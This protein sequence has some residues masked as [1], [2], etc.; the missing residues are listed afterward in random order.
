MVANAMN[1]PSPEN[2]LR[3]KRI[4]DRLK[5]IKGEASGFSAFLKSE[6]GEPTK[7]AIAL[8]EELNQIGGHEAMRYASKQ[9]SILDQRELDFA[10][11]A[12]TEGKFQPLTF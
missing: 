5:T 4:I 7:E 6:S 3:V 12:V 11:L 1:N 9:L 2:D 10:F 8:A